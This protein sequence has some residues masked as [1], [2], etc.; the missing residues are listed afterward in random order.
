MG[1]WEAKQRPTP[2]VEVHC[3]ANHIDF[4]RSQYFPGILA[5]GNLTDLL[6][7]GIFLIR[8]TRI[9]PAPSGKSRRREGK[10][11]ARTAD[12]S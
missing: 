12:Q 8:T 3:S 5:R 9:F 10:R 7:P 4:S 6:L 11:S 2:N 1:T